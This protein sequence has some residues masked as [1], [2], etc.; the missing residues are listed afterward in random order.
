[1]PPKVVLQSG[2]TAFAGNDYLGLSTDPR[3]AQALSD[4]AK[5]YGISSTSSRWALGWTEAHAQLGHDLAAFF[6]V[7]DAC[8]IGAT[9]LGGAIYYDVL[10]KTHDNVFCDEQVHSNQ[11]M[12]L[13]DAGFTILRFQHLNPADLRE[14]LSSHT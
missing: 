14:K 2:Q 3:L 1:M 13:Q 11:I 10:R 9:Y 6:G 4:A 8:I 12:G 7:E 5:R